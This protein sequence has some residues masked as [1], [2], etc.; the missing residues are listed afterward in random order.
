[1]TVSGVGNPREYGGQ[2]ARFAARANAVARIGLVPEPPIPNAKHLKSRGC[3]RGERH[4]IHAKAK[5][6]P[7]FWENAAIAKKTRISTAIN[8]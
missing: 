3:S 6:V 2:E 7:A 5:T 8:R 4:N 1:M